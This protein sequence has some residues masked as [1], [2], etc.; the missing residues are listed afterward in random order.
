MQIR[1]A[2]PADFPRILAL[3]EES[4]QFLSPL[5]PKRLELLHDEAA[6]HRVMEIDGSVVAFLLAL[7]QG[8]TY[9]SPNYHWFAS[10]FDSFIYVDRIVVA[11]AHQARGV[12]RNLYED[13]FSFAKQGNITLV[14]CEFDVD[15]PNETSRRFH[16][17]FGFTEA[18]TQRVGLS[19]KR[20]SLQTLPIRS[21]SS[22]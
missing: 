4:V 15:P 2:L 17:R 14:A 19:G 21:A 9:D 22:T 8:C 16:R 18:G 12:G 3:N 1:D 20:V 5:S 7:P 11:V 10:H 13:L 6:Y